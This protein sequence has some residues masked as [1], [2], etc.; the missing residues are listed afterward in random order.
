ML[1]ITCKHRLKPVT[2]IIN[3]VRQSGDF[4]LS[5]HVS[6]I[7]KFADLYNLWLPDVK[8]H[9][10]LLHA[11]LRWPCLPP[12][13][14]LTILAWIVKWR[15]LLHLTACDPLAQNLGAAAHRRQCKHINLAT[16]LV[17]CPDYLPTAFSVLLRALHT[18]RVLQIPF[19]KWFYS[20]IK[21]IIVCGLKLF[22]KMTWMK[23]FICKLTF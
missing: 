7:S 20:L 17:L 16:Y 10:S 3:N 8:R 4:R 12:F 6:F 15:L 5:P 21:S 19:E 23:F 2:S 11:Q 22:F 1:E 14:F 13:L 18:S 9:Q